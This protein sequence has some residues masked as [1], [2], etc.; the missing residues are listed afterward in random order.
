M[1]NQ[2]NSEPILL[3]VKDIQRI[4]G[5]SLKKAYKIMH[6]PGFPSFKLDGILYVEEC[7]FRKWV[8]KCEHKDIFT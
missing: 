5:C 3:R 1:K 4:F 7:A 6:I 8:S 2:D